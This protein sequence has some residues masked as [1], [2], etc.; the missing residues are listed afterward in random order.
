MNATNIPNPSASN[1]YKLSL[2]KCVLGSWSS[3]PL[4][5]N[6]YFYDNGTNSGSLLGGINA[7]SAMDASFYM[8][9]ATYHPHTWD[10][11]TISGGGATDWPRWGQ[12]GFNMDEMPTNR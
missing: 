2:N 5:Y 9:H 11:W 12:L 4:P 1:C 3:V 7:N 8:L 6:S 10:V